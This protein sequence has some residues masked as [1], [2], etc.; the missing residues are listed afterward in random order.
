[1]GG[2][3]IMVWEEMK[4]PK[5]L[6]KNVLKT[7]VETLL[8]HQMK[9]LDKDFDRV[10]ED[11]MKRSSSFTSNS[12]NL[13]FLSSENT[14]RTKKLILPTTSPQL[15]NEDLQQ[16]DEDDLEELDLRWQVAMLT[17]R[18]CNS[19]RNQRKRPYGDNGRKNASTNEPSSQALVAQDGLGGYDWSHDF[20]EPVNYALMAISSS[21]SS[22]SSDNE[23]QNCSKQCIESFKTLQKN[24]DSEREK[25]NRAR[26]EIQG[27]ELALESLESRILGRKKN[28]LAWGEKYDQ[29]S[30]HDKNG[31]GY[32]TQLNEMSDK[33]ETD[34]EISMSVFEVRSSDEESTPA[35]DRFSKADGYHAVPPPITG[36]FLTPRADISFAGLDEYAIRKKIIES[37]TTELNADT[38][39]SKTSETVVSPVKTNENS[40]QLKIKLI[41][42]VKFYGKQ[43][44]YPK[45][46]LVNPV[47]PNE[48]RAVQTIN[49]VRP[50]NP[51]IFLQDH[52]AV[53]SGCSSHM[54]GNKAYISDYEDLQCEDF[55]IG[56]EDFNTGSLGVSTGSGPVS[57]PTTKRTKAQIQ[58]E[59]AGLAEA[60]RL[61]ALQEEEA[62]RQDWDTIRAKLEANTELTKSLQGESMT[63]EDFAKK[64]VEMINIVK[65]SSVLKQKAKAVRSKPMDKKHSKRDYMRCKTDE[66]VKR[67][68]SW[69]EFSKKQKT[70]EEVSVLEESI[71]EPVIA[72]EEE[73]KK[74]VKKRGKIR[75]QKARKGIH[76]DKTA[77]D[78]SE[79][80]REAF[81][82]DKVTSASSESEIGI[83]A[84]P[85]ATK[86]LLVLLIRRSFLK[87]GL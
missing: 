58:Q 6:Q 13:A 34:S 37:K 10:Y 18:E 73:I 25:H 71:T 82:K 76:I 84:I 61:Q 31:L 66:R 79:E 19:G 70:I 12:Q 87:S 47:R 67:Q 29:M 64:M 35:N 78:E 3:S 56:N 48:K 1:M 54:T 51:E 40:I 5:S 86:N 68:C 74:S 63:S 8:C 59:E 17:V 50:G 69:A 43:V 36:N 24:Y 15:E 55:N 14:S 45:T 33:S 77:Q 32:G 44:Y 26:L 80:E 46:G 85:T 42:L 49:T 4:N 7:S 39:K 9:S 52:A 28:E 65:R 75:K 23:V 30:A 16:I 83:D 53:D 60:M 57:T 22:S 81:M 72:K 2:Q 21:N 41:K 62:A 38:S 11:E 20:D 27:Y